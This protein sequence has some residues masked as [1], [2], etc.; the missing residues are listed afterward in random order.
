M[1]SITQFCVGALFLV[2]V[3]LGALVAYLAKLL[4]DANSRIALSSE[5]S[6]LASKA[7][8]PRALANAIASLEASRHD[9]AMLQKELRQSL[10][11][12]RNLQADTPDDMVEG[13][14]MYI[15]GLALD[16]IKR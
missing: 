3:G 4:S 13:G 7:E 16:P 2:I 9:N 6:L 12:A 14:T 1:D 15:G 8:D 11:V 10:P 5:K